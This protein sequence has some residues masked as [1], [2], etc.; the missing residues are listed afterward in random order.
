MEALYQDDKTRV[1]GLAHHKSDGTLTRTG[2]GS[3]LPDID[4]VH[5]NTHL[6]ITFEAGYVFAAVAND[7]NADLLVRVPAGKVAHT[8]SEGASGGEAYGFIYED[9]VTSAVGTQLTVKNKNRASANVASV[10]VYRGP[11][12]TGVG[13]ELHQGYSPGG[14]GGNSQGSTTERRDEFI[15]REGYYLFR[16]TNK[17][18]QAKTLFTELRWYEKDA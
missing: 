15:L 16:T 3:P 4:S 14:T 17:A 13:T 11:T 9:V 6:G 2:S 18:G 1:H 7:G 12:V 5:L 10:T 8:V